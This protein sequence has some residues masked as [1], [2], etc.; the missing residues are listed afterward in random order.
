LTPEDVLDFE[1]AIREGGI[2][3]F[4]TDTV[5]GIGCRPGDEAALARVYELKG[6]AAET[7]SATMWF[8]LEA[9]LA[10]LPDQP[11]RTR[12]ALKRLLPGPVLVVLRGGQGVRVPLLTGELAPL[13][14]SGVAVVQTSANLTGEPAPRRLADVPDRLREAADVVLDGGELPGTPSTVVDLTR[15]EDEGRWEAL[16]VGAIQPGELTEL[17]GDYPL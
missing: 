12:G 8:Q 14:E 4:P 10:A 17:L 13:A 6:R 16:R 9:G 5:Y 3:V 15:Y 2:A 11:L 1:R 7:P